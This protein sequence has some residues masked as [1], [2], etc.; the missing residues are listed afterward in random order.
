MAEGF[1]FTIC[2]TGTVAGAPP[3]DGIEMSHVTSAYDVLSLE[4][5]DLG[6]V[7]ILGG[8]ALGCY[9]ALYLSNHAKSV[10]I[11]D[12]DETLGID[13]GR[14]TRWVVLQALKDKN[15]QTNLDAEVVQINKKY[16]T[17][18]QDSKYYHVNAD[19]VVLATKPQPRERILKQLE[20]KGIKNNQVGSLNGFT[21]LLDTIHDAFRFA[22]TFTL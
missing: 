3:I 19:T 12:A 1:D 17:V 20:K 5:E 14:S 22:S 9:T 8:R 4:L 13:I 10:Q 7:V 18:I 15:V 6:H 11:I 16:L 21:N 2:A